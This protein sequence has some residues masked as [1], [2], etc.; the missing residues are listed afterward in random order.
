MDYGKY[1]HYRRMI[2]ECLQQRSKWGGSHTSTKNMLRKIPHHDWGSKEAR[3]AA[4]DL[5]K[6]GKIMIKK[7]VEDDHVSLNPRLVDEIRREI[8]NFKKE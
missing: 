7:T 6:E 5:I 1:R 2:L 4:S 3:Q 8:Y